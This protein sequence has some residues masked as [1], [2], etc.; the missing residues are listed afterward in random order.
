MKRG[1]EQY[2]EFT[3]RRFRELSIAI[4]RY[5]D[6]IG[7]RKGKMVGLI[8]ENRPEWPIIYFAILRTGATVVPMD[9][10]L[11][12]AEITHIIRM[13]GFRFFLFGGAV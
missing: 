10:L 11:G 3:Y 9:A 6:D 1:G 4:A 2:D 8:S 7:V 12:E 13:P 5:L